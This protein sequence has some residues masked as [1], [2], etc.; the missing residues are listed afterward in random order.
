MV[1]PLRRLAP[2]PHGANPFSEEWAAEKAE[3]VLA[4][5]L[6]AGILYSSDFSS[7]Q[8][9][10]WVVF[11]GVFSSKSAAQSHRSKVVAKG[12]SEAVVIQVVPK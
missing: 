9:G 12:Y 2:L 3:A 8:E 11:S 5:R 4:D 7:I 1:R 10:W 6:P